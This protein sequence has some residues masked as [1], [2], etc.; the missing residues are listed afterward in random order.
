MPSHLSSSL[1]P[2]INLCSFSQ[3]SVVQMEVMCH[4]TYLLN[5]AAALAGW[6]NAMIPA[7]ISLHAFSTFFSSD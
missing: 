1:A 6:R 2:P 7:T 4:G 3:H 5:L